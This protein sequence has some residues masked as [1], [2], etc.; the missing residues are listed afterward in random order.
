MA[1]LKD[2][3]TEEMKNAMRAGEKERLA[4]IRLIL[5]AI[6]QREVD[7]RIQLDD[8]QVLAV[9]EKMVKQR[10][11][12]IAQFEAGGRADLVAKEQAEMAV[13]Q[14]YLPAQMSDV[15]IDALIAEAVASTGAASI[16]DMGKVMAAVK[17]KAQGRAD[18]GAVSAR[19]KQ[20]LSG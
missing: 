2:R 15:E 8:T 9:V 12:S 3:I 16:K 7:E 4:T 5:S 6:K 1:A 11:E 14:T 19:I 13:L 20:K 18:M 17:A 10:K